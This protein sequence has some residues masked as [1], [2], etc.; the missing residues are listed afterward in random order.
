MSKTRLHR[1]ASLFSK[2]APKPGLTTLPRITETTETVSD[3]AKKPNATATATSHP[4]TP[5]RPITSAESLIPERSL[6]PT[7]PVLPTIYITRRRRS[8]LVLPSD[9]L[10]EIFRK[11][12]TT[13]P[14][15]DKPYEAAV[16]ILKIAIRSLSVLSTHFKNTMRTDN[17]VSSNCNRRRLETLSQKI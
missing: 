16:A 5:P 9:V 1:H 3:N 8:S 6:T 14:A 10:P 11:E 17:I 2:T 12:S 15:T 7:K 4:V 13:I